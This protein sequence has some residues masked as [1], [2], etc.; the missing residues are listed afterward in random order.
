MGGQ[1]V[2]D[3]CYLEVKIP[4]AS[5][6]NPTGPI[7][8]NH[9][10]SY[11]ATGAKQIMP[12]ATVITADDQ[13]VGVGQTVAIGATAN[14]GAAITYVSNNTSVATVDADG[15]IT[16]VATGST[17]ITLSAAAVEGEYAAATKTINVE[18]TAAFT[19]AITIDGDFSDW[20]G[21][22]EYAGTRPGGGSNTRI[23]AWR[24][25]SDERNMYFYLELNT[26]K[27]TTARYIYVGF[28]T[29]RDESHGS[30]Y[31]NIPGCEQYVKVYPT[32]ADSS[33]IAFVNGADP[34]SSVNSSSDG[35]DRTIEIWSVYGNPSTSVF[36]EL[37][38]PRSKVGL[39]SAGTVD[40]AV[41]YDSYN[42]A[43]QALVLQ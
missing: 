9:A 16:G 13:T 27:I 41:T 17:T 4:L 10:M 31:G 34:R 8:V 28:D 5:I 7:T 19:P 20:E 24:M 33:P 2:G 25:T 40:V 43:K 18:V 35:N 37:C 1:I 36:V 6:G 23:N 3:Y 29:D 42:T 38:I 30:S 22:T 12:E 39:M 11:Y 26:E 15:V 21:I 32:V 14:S